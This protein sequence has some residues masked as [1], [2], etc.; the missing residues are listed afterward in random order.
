MTFLNAGW[1][2]IDPVNRRRWELVLPIG[3]VLLD[4]QNALNFFKLVTYLTMR[5]FHLKKPAF[6]TVPDKSKD[7]T[8][9]GKS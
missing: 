4:L 5:I 7:Q 3:C 2:L 8:I 9:L 1:V 6:L